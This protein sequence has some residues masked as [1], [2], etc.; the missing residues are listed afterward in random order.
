MKRTLISGFALSVTFLAGLAVAH[1]GT[2]EYDSGTVREYDGIVAEQQWKNPHNLIVLETESEGEPLRLEIEGAGASTLRTL[3]VTADSITVGEYVTAVVNPSRRFSNRAAGP[4]P[5][6]TTSTFPGTGIGLGR[7][8][9]LRA[10][11][12]SR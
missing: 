2:S 6:T 11:W 8:M 12:D 7:C 3:G 10:A 4:C 9:T 5:C 1:H